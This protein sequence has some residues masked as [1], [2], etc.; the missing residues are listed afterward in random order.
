MLDLRAIHYFLTYLLSLSLFWPQSR[1]GVLHSR[2]FSQPA[3][4]DHIVWVFFFVFF[5]ELRMKEAR[6]MASRITLRICMHALHFAVKS[7]FLF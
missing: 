7:N 6:E 1:T 5:V 3:S 2:S 4:T